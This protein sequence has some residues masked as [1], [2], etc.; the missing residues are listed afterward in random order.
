ME[1]KL[2]EL[3]GVTSGRECLLSEN[4]QLRAETIL[5]ALHAAA[6]LARAEQIERD[7]GIAAE[8][9]SY[10]LER[11]PSDRDLGWKRCARVI[12]EAIRAQLKE[13]G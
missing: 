3:A 8:K 12:E 11:N 9:K 5:T 1:E 2:R 4:P 7:A 13:R 6:D 10:S